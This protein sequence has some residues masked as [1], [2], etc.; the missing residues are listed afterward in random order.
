[1]LRAASSTYFELRPHTELQ[2]KFKEVLRDSTSFSPRRNEI[3]HGYVD[4]F[5]TEEE[6]M[7]YGWISDATGFGLYPSLASFKERDL[8]AKPSYCMTSAEI[9]YFYS[10]IVRIQPIAVRLGDAIRKH[11]AGAS[12]DLTPVSHPAITRVRG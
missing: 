12:F 4:Q 11:G 2:S 5:Q 1:M 6:W 10:Q 8:N 9:L 3:A 7:R